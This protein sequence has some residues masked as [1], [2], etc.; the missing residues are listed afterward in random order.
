MRFSAETTT[1][2]VTERLFTIDGAP[3]A[4]WAP[5]GAQGTRPL[6]LLGHGGGAHGTQCD[7]LASKE[8]TLH[9]NPGRHPDGPAFEVDS[10]E[11]FFARHLAGQA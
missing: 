3:G 11:R 7:A 1:D 9:A 10:S 5:A 6:I 2:A 8:K 4:V